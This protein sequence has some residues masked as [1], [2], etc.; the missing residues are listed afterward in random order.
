MSQ[1]IVKRQRHWSLARPADKVLEVT[2][3]ENCLASGT[4][5]LLMAD[6]Y[7]RIDKA[8]KNKPKKF[9]SKQKRKHGGIGKWNID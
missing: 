3:S 9:Q 6:L 2:S 5:P 8:S 1:F 7:T 4:I